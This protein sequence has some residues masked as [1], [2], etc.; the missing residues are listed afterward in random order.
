MKQSFSI[1]LVILSFSLYSQSL[2]FGKSIPQNRNC[3]TMQHLEY[4]KSNDPD[5]QNR[6]LKNENYLQQVI[7]SQYQFK[8]FNIKS[9]YYQI[10]IAT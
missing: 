9:D 4:L 1:L 5:L 2:Y 10:F 6:M 7:K 3:G 8:S